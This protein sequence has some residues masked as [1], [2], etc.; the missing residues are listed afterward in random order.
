MKTS[1]K[2]QKCLAILLALLILS[3]CLPVMATE[4]Q[5]D[6]ENGLHVFAA[7]APST[8]EGHDGY[9]SLCGVALTGPHTMGWVDNG[10]GTHSEGCTVCHYIPESAIPEAHSIDHTDAVDPTC[11]VDGTTTAYCKCGATV[12]Q[13]T[14][15]LGHDVD[16]GV[17]TTEPTC[18]TEGVR[19]YTCRRCGETATEA[20][21]ALGHDVD[22]GVVTTEPTTTEEGVMTY[23]CRRCGQTATQPIPATGES[24]PD[25]EKT[26]EHVY[27]AWTDAGEQHIR[28]CELCNDQQTEDHSYDEGTVLQP[29]TESSEGVMTYTCTVCGHEKTEPIPVTAPQECEHVYGAWTFNETQHARTC[30]K[31]N[32]S[33]IS[34]HT[35]DEGT[36]T[37][38]GTVYTC[39]VCGYQKTET[40]PAVEHHLSENWTAKEGDDTLHYKTCS[41]DGCDYSISEPHAFDAGVVTTPATETS[42]GVMT[43]TCSACGYQKAESI[44]AV[45]HH[46]SENW[47]AKEGDDTLH[48]KTCTDDGCDYSISEP[49]AFDAGVVTTSA[50]E[51]TEGV[52][53]Y[54][55]SACGYQKTETI[56]AVEHHLSENWTAKEG[57]DALHY[58]TC[59]DDGCDYSISEPHAF[60]AGVVTKPATE[61][62]NGVM[63]YTC[64]VC[65]YQ[66]TADIPAVN[67]NWGEWTDKPDDDANHY[68]YCSDPG[69]GMFYAEPH[70]YTETITPATCQQEG[71]IVRTC[72]VCGH[73]VET[74][75]AK[76]EHT[77]GEWTANETQH[78]RECTVCH[79]KE[80]AD[81]TFGD[82]W[83]DANQD[84][85]HHFMTCTVCGATLALEHT[86]DEGTVVTAATP[87]ATGLK[88]YKCKGTGCT[89]SKFETLPKTQPA[90]T[91]RYLYFTVSLNCDS[92][93]GHNSE[94][95][96]LAVPTAD[97]G[98]IYLGSDGL[99]RVERTMD[100]NQN[101][102]EYFLDLAGWKGSHK[103]V[104]PSDG[105]LKLTAVLNHDNVWKTE[106]VQLT[107]EDVEDYFTVKFKSGDKVVETYVIKA[108]EK[109][110]KLPTVNDFEF[111]GWYYK[112]GTKVSENDIVNDNLTVYAR[113]SYDVPKT[114]NNDHQLMI[115][116][117]CVSGALLVVMIFSA[118]QM[119]RLSRKSRR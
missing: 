118:V 106:A 78:T 52:M 98:Q 23:T 10:D 108:G 20:I 110:G 66:K 40:I 13:T 25:T 49:H 50:T 22:E 5:P 94:T 88:E 80:S 91:D 38:G 86:W 45:E 111:L 11:T 84:A 113:Y 87:Y 46:L 92:G 89:A 4:V 85:E 37:E 47:T 33:E 35:F 9:C 93:E 29:A 27:G 12:V 117:L 70:N 16:E 90:L 7:N 31:C 24:Q 26:C 95:V 58:K 63:T 60:D 76:V 83:Y 75:L 8:E 82:C 15:A 62:E 21:A 67:H 44:P 18:E 1:S 55:C 115:I 69:C 100:I 43:Y 57:D 74:K 6:C 59:T 36:A 68:K 104:A 28:V 109:I 32:A 103:L 105:K 17:V 54:T 2:I 116:L 107:F 79:E 71:K 56:P 30:E 97:F 34:D 73:T 39:T 101:W 61:T 3:S 41:D 65:G 77:W 14:P 96:D 119:I 48:Y 102:Q 114:G 99:Y 19:T 81:H 53:T 72:T 112:N 64:S 51:T 42:E